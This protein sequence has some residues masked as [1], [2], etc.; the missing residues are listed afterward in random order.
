MKR[1]LSILTLLLISLSICAYDFMVNGLYYNVIGDNEVEVTYS[2]E[3]YS[4]DITI[5]EKVEYN[6]KVYNVTSIGDYA[7]SGSYTLTSIDLPNNVTSIGYLSFGTCGS[8]T[9]I[10]LPNNLKSIGDYAF[11]FCVGLISITIPNNVTTIG[12]GAFHCCTALVSVASLNTVPPQLAYQSFD[13]NKVVYNNDLTLCV[14]KGCKTIYSQDASWSQFPYIIGWG[15]PN[16]IQNIRSSIVGTWKLQRTT[17]S[18]ELSD[19]KYYYFKADGSFFEVVISQKFFIYVEIYK[20][21]WSA[22]EGRISIVEKEWFS[23][24]KYGNTLFG[25]LEDNYYKY[26]LSLFSVTESDLVVIDGNNYTIYYEKVGYSDIMEYMPPEYVDE[27]DNQG[28]ETSKSRLLTIHYDNGTDAKYKMDDIS[29][30]SITPKQNSSEDGSAVKLE[31]GGTSMTLSLG[32]K[33]QIVNE[34][35]IIILKTSSMTVTLSVPCKATFVGVS[36]TS[37]DK[38]VLRN[39]EEDKPIDVFTID[40]RKVTTLKGKNETLSL[41]KGVYIINGKK[42]IIK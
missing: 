20:G 9:S 21:T 25:D 31:Y 41:E 32:Q 3:K 13:Y 6:G 36:D 26:E 35:D 12:E 37:I 38:V 10:F 39:N 2:D 15:D 30:I 5:P 24:D 1:I 14:P 16:N 18:G 33:P 22:S 19:M 29:S 40:G 11:N 17:N 8:L 27:G 4:G 7:F 34:G 42:M 28:S 23:K